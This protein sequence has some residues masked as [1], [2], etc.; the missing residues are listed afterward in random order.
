[1]HTRQS[2]SSR[3]LTKKVAVDRPRFPG[4]CVPRSKG[5]GLVGQ[6]RKATEINKVFPPLPA[7]HMAPPC[8]P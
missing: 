1:M 5:Q 4:V 6:F 3:P 2:W 7:R 8:D